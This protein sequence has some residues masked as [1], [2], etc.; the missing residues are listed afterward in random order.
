MEKAKNCIVIIKDDFKN[1]LLLQKKVK[2]TEPKIWYL[3]ES[4][5]K[6]K[7]TEEKSIDKN[8]KKSINTIIFNKKVFKDYTLEGT[9]EIT[10]V[11]TGQL[12]ERI[13]LHKEYTASKWVGKKEI[14]DMEIAEEHK[15]I[16]REFFESL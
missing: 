13:V 2:R 1:I 9:E 10:R 3:I 14:E 12:K 5:V 6:G 4:E 11:Y 16:L 8:I 7:A 15:N